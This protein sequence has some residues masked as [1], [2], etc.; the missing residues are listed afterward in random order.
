MRL[1]GVF[2][3]F[4][5]IAS[6][7][8]FNVKKTSSE[9]ILKEELKTFNWND[10]DEY[11]SF[12]VC[13]SLIDS[14]E[15]QACFSEVLTSHILG[16]LQHEM[17]IVTKDVNDTINLEFKLSEQGVLTLVEAKIDSLTMAE[18]PNLQELISQSLDSL[19]KIFP[20]S[21]HGQQVKTAFNLPIII[22]VE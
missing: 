7:D 22:N 9:A 13:D 14:K 19:P 11:P 17:I 20:A 21:K 1:I 15:K 5:L 18:I 3:I 16:F 4:S 10:V 12:S 2:L 8:Y 6:C